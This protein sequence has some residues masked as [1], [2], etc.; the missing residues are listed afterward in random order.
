MTNKPIVENL[1]PEFKDFAPDL[2]NYT[3]D[4]LFEKVWLDG[5]LDS[6]TRSIVTLTLLATLGN[7]EQ[8]PFHLETAAKNGV[9][10]KELSALCT[11]L[12]F[13]IGW[14]QAMLLLNQIIK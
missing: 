3:N 4:I 6:K 10:Q 2:A 5:Q 8:M 12:A 1:S 11:H 9:S 14:P 13:Y 7:T